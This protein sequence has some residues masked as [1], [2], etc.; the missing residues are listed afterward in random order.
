MKSAWRE[1]AAGRGAEPPRSKERGPVE[2]GCPPRS[3]RKWLHLRA[4]RSAALLKFTG[5]VAGTAGTQPN[6]RAQRSAALLKYCLRCSMPAAEADLRAQRSAALLKS[7]VRAARP[8]LDR[9]DLRAQRSAALLKSVGPAASGPSHGGPPRS[10][11]RG[12]VEVTQRGALAM[13]LFGR[14]P[15]SKER[16]PVEVLRTAGQPRPMT[17]DLRAQRS[18]ALLKCG[19]PGRGPRRRGTSALKGARPC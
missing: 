9:R 13:N 7:L 10:K 18:A 1:G 19:A 15:R 8:R 17:R 2:V 5:K 4:Q 6:L 16:G 12:P 11:E 3:R 14:P